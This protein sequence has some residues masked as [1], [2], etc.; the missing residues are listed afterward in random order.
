MIGRAKELIE[1]ANLPINNL[2]TISLTDLNYISVAEVQYNLL[3][4]KKDKPIE[5]LQ[6]DFLN[7]KTSKYNNFV[8]FFTDGSR[9]NDKTG[10]AFVTGDTTE[11]NRLPSTCSVYT[12]EMYAVYRAIKFICNSDIERAVIFSDSLSVL[13]SIESFKV[14]C[15]Y[16]T[17]LQKLLATSGK[18]IVLEWVPAHVGIHGNTC[19]DAAA[20]SATEKDDYL[21]TKLHFY[22]LRTLIKYFIL[23]HWQADWSV[24]NCPTQ[25]LKPILGDWKSAYTENRC[26]EIV[27]A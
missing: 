2:E 18:Q 17:K 3:T 9:I 22:D 23:Q 10:Y 20:K 13:Q 8:S 27:L 12:A 11:S 16:M 1:I 4:K 6:Q 5:E 25:R 15:H 24:T 14:K 26:E 19:A 7:L 21:N